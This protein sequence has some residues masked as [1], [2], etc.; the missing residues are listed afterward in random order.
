VEV[1]AGNKNYVNS[2]Y[3]NSTKDKVEEEE[4]KDNVDNNILNFLKKA[5]D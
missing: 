3:N 1:K 4:V 2:G 5:I